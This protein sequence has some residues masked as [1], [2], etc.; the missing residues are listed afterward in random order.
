MLFDFG[1]EIGDRIMMS[2]YIVSFEGFVLIFCLSS[3]LHNFLE[4]SLMNEFQCASF[5][6]RGNHSLKNASSLI[7]SLTEDV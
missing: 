5:L 3:T 1:V 4:W 7:W 6:V 2:G